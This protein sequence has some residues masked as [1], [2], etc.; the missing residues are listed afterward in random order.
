MRAWIA[1]AGAA[2]VL[3]AAWPAAADWQNTK[4]GM[5]KEE[6]AA[7]YPDQQL[8]SEGNETWSIRTNI[9]LAGETF[10]KAYFIFNKG[11]LSAVRLVGSSLAAREVERAL[12]ARY[13]QAV[14]N[15][16]A[17]GGSTYSDL[18]AGN[19]IVLLQT[20]GSTHLIYKPV[21]KGF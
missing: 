5:S 16:G 6:V 2:G 3:S 15:Q 8:S 20:V 19:Y 10:D 4:W 18:Q 13:G 7:V 17:N 9:S 1:A 21:E 11:R 12:A 14:L